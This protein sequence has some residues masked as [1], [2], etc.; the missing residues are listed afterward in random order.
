MEIGRLR[1]R[2]FDL[3]VSENAFE[4]LLRQGIQT[5]LG[6]RPMKK[7]VQKFIGDTIRDAMKLGRLSCGDLAVSPHDDRLII[8]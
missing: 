2:S 6:A 7:T 5:T 4:F 8:M 3:I 1:A